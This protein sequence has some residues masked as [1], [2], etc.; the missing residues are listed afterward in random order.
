[1]L[2][3]GDQG[4]KVGIDVSQHRGRYGGDGSSGDRTST[5]R[6]GDQSASDSPVAVHERVNRLELPVNE[7]RLRQWRHIA[8]AQECD[9][10]RHQWP[11]VAWWWWH[12]YGMS[13][14]EVATA[15]PVLDIP[16][17]TRMVVVRVV[18]VEQ[19]VCVKNRAL[20]EVFA[21]FLA[22][23]EDFHCVRR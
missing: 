9:E 21:R 14:A 5:Q 2:A 8:A 16:V 22:L 19:A 20:G 6:D 12:V 4:V 1:T 17:A 10:V 3:V 7:S 13:G 11:H 18:V 15:D 23:D